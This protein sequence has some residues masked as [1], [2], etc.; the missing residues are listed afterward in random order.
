MKQFETFLRKIWIFVNYYVPLRHVI[1][2]SLSMKKTVILPWVFLS[3]CSCQEQTDDV[4]ETLR[5]IQDYGDKEP[6][7]ALAKLDSIGG[8]LTLDSEYKRQ[9]YALLRIRLQDKSYV[10]PTSDK[11]IKKVVEYFSNHGSLREKQEAYHFAGSVYCDLHDAPNSIQNFLQSIYWADHAPETC[12]STLLICS[13]SSL[14]HLYNITAMYQS[15]LDAAKKELEI[16]TAMNDFIPSTWTHLADGYYNCDSLEQAFKYYDYSLDSQ[17]NAPHR[18]INTLSILLYKYAVN[19][20]EEKADL[21][22]K[23]LMETMPQAPTEPCSFTSLCLGR[24]HRYKNN[25]DSAIYYLSKVLNYDNDLVDMY[26]ASKDLY[27]IS[28]QRGKIKEALHYCD[29]FIAVND[30]LVIGKRQ[31]ELNSTNNWFQ[32]IRDKEEEEKLQ[33]ENRKYKEQFVQAIYIATFLALFAITL[34]FYIRSRQL[35][36]IAKLNDDIQNTSKEL[37]RVSNELKENEKLLEEKNK[38]NNEIISLLHQNQLETN[39]ED[40]IKKLKEAAANCSTLSIQEWNNLYQAVDNL[41][42]DFKEEVHLKLK[43]L[44][45]ERKNVCYLKKAGFTTTQIMALTNASRTTVWRLIKQL[46]E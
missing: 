46:E 23:L 16:S 18:D 39:S 45:S 12:D 13:Y 43:P 5:A 11:P 19:N 4:L 15:F 29:K 33:E 2:P 17:L 8:N 22:A 1:H 6:Q 10:V 7:L 26:T 32:Y 44:S 27:E 41:W 25:P 3:L 42:P 36:K 38:R 14:C 37:K 24:Y 21:C 20:K 30:S 31:E 28:L 35:K 9:K 40:I 34:F